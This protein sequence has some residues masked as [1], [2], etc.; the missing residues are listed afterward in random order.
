MIIHAQT[1]REDQIDQFKKEGMV[2]SY[3]A[4]HTF[5]WGDWHRDSVLG[6]ERGRRISPLASIL[7]K[8][9]PFTIHNDSPVVPPDMMRLVWAAVNRITRSGQTLGVEQKISAEEALKAI[10]ISGAYQYFEED[11]KGSLEAGKQADMVILDENPLRV[12][13]LNIKDI[14]VVETIKDGEIVYKAD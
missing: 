5:F 11:K 2:P 4:A 13:P 12:D 8:G 1:V 14:R 7:K 6:P 10:T 3:F 9:V